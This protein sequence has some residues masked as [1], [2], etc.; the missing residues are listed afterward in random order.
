IALA[1]L[2]PAQSAEVEVAEGPISLWQLALP[3][4]AVFAAA[5][6]VLRLALIGQN[7]DRFGTVL[8]GSIGILFVANQILTHRDSLD[9]LDQS[10]LME[11]LLA[12]RNN[13]LDQIVSHAP[14]GIA[15][16]GADMKI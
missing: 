6:T 14:L 8:A 7:L 15:R 13:L 11:A 16:V 4:L 2:W 9:L 3:W 10:H 1:P 5:V 12:R